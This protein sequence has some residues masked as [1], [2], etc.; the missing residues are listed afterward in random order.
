[1]KTCVFCG[2]DYPDNPLRCPNCDALLLVPAVDLIPKPV[3]PASVRIRTSRSKV[4]FAL[5]WWVASASMGFYASVLS[6]TIEIMA[7]FFWVTIAC[8]ALLIFFAMK[9]KD[10]M[11]YLCSVMPVPLSLALSI[12]LLVTGVII[13]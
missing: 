5:F 8:L 6:L 10:R 12:A 11:V 7:V 1:M 2:R 13:Y 4:L 9:G 3:R